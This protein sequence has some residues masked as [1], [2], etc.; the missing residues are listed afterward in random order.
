MRSDHRVRLTKGYAETTTPSR[1]MIPRPIVERELPELLL[2]PEQ[3]NVAVGTTGMTVTE[4]P[5]LDV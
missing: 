4:C 2:S 1:P 5:D 3:V